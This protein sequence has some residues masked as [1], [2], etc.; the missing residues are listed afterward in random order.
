MWPTPGAD[1]WLEASATPV[2]TAGHEFGE[3]TGEWGMVELPVGYSPSLENQF[4]PSHAEWL[5]AR[6]D[7]T[8]GVRSR[9]EN[10][11]YAA[12][13]RF[14]VVQN[15]MAQG[16]FRVEHGGYN[17]G[18]LNVAAVRTFTAP[19]SSRSEYTV[20]PWGFPTSRHTVLSLSW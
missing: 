20:R 7:A 15:S 17:D 10:V 12:M 14:N 2:A 19:C 5:H 11:P 13:T 3:L 8:T 9:D 18:N 4:D 1:A 6:Y 16:G